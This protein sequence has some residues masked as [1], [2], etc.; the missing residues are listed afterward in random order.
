MTPHST[1]SLQ[2]IP[3][4]YQEQSKYQVCRYYMFSPLMLL[5]KSTQPTTVK[6]LPHF[7]RF[8]NRFCEQ[9]SSPALFKH[10]SRRLWGY[11]WELIRVIDTD[12]TYSQTLPFLFSTH[13]KDNVC[14]TCW[15]RHLHKTACLLD[16]MASW[17]RIV[18]GPSV[19]PYEPYYSPLH[20]DWLHAASAM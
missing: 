14:Q 16:A 18:S 2:S 11:D 13:M 20:H 5:W 3:K 7:L 4:A 8:L 10:L 19:E 12:H 17:R 6:G 15:L 9:V 1:E